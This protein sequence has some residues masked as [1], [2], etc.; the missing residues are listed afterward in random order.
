MAYS[1]SERSLTTMTLEGAV[2]PAPVV[3][4]VRAVPNPSSAPHERDPAAEN[5]TVRPAKRTRNAAKAEAPKKAEAAPS[6]NPRARLDDLERRISQLEDLIEDRFITFVPQPGTQLN[7][8][9]RISE[10]YGE[11][12]GFTYAY[13]NRFER[14]VER[15]EAVQDRLMQAYASPWG[16]NGSRDARNGRRRGAPRW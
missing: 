10:V 11:G 4:V 5:P 6:N 9:A 7:G 14:L 2:W 16:P 13:R 12:E 8:V 1:A 15:Y 3:R